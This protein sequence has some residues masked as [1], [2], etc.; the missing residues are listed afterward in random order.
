M[1]VRTTLH[2]DEQ[3]LES[4]RRYVP[5][6]GLSRF[7]NQTLAEKA[8]AMERKRIEDL[9]VEGYRASWLEQRDAEEDWRGDRG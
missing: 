3:V 2:L 8:E 6:C 4:V 5:A 1:P 7:I 9:M